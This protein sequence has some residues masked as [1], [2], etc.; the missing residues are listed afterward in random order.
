MTPEQEKGAVATGYVRQKLECLLRD[1]DSYTAGEFW[2]EMAR[3]AEGATGIPHAESLARELAEHSQQTIETKK[4]LDLLSGNPT[5][6]M[7]VAGQRYI[8]S[9][10]VSLIFEVMRDQALQSS[11]G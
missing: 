9:Y 8:Y 11:Q 7:V 10:D 2:R 6:D 3:I 4:K 1:L 5:E